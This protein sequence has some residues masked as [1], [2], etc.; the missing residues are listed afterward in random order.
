MC[1][2]YC[3]QTWWSTEAQY[4]ILWPPS[5]PTPAVQIAKWCS[6]D[7]L[8]NTA[9]VTTNTVTQRTQHS[10][11]HHNTTTLPHSQG[12]HKHHHYNYFP[13]PNNIHRI[14]PALALDMLLCVSAQSFWTFLFNKL[15]TKPIPLLESINCSKSVKSSLNWGPEEASSMSIYS[16]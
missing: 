9:R 3:H 7:Y 1:N 8:C 4:R 16:S 10:Q 2:T 14:A 5:L 12:H 6:G 13:L 15:N 11:G